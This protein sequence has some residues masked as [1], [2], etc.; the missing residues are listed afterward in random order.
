MHPDDALD[1]VSYASR[2]YGQESG[3]EGF[4]SDNRTRKIASL[5]YSLVGAYERDGTTLEDF[6]K[7]V[8]QRH[9]EDR[10]MPHAHAFS[11]EWSGARENA[12]QKGRISTCLTDTT[13]TSEVT[14]LQVAMSPKRGVDAENT[15][16]SNEQ[17][18]DSA[19]NVHDSFYSASSDP[20]EEEASHL[21]ILPTSREL[22]PTP[23]EPLKP[24][25]KVRFDEQDPTC[26]D[27]DADSILEKDKEGDHSPTSSSLDE[28]EGSL[29]FIDL[30]SKRK[31][32]TCKSEGLEPDT[33][34]SLKTVCVPFD[35]DGDGEPVSRL[36]CSGVHAP[37]AESIRGLY[38]ERALAQ[39][40]DP[41]PTSLLRTKDLLKSAS[42]SL[43]AGGAGLAQRSARLWHDS[44]ETRQ[45]LGAGVETLARHGREG[46]IGLAGVAGSWAQGM[47]EEQQV[48]ARRDLEAFNNLTSV[49][50]I[51]RRMVAEKQRPS[52]W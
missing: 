40:T 11:Q 2:R 37:T 44:A 48:N 22:S 19:A 18:E 52:Y 36:F 33:D 45:S 29:V 31:C 1:I 46:A 38:P 50:K 30:P 5:V 14:S 20:P 24:E 39:D 6:M 42:Q 26:T 41:T 47:L 9:G 8:E 16:G 21:L 23:S 35:T 4:W 15:P 28:S 34:E 10:F 3:V 43:I 12:S 49:E 32:V 25:D 17:L 51:A 27:S 7:T 13:P